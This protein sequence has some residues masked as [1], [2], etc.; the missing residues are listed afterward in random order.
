[1]E[2]TTESRLK[3]LTT[4]SGLVIQFKHEKGSWPQAIYR[5][6]KKI[7]VMVTRRTIC[8]IVKPLPGMDSASGFK[9]EALCSPSDN[10]EYEL[11]RQIALFDVLKTAPREA[12]KEVMETYLGRPGAKPWRLDKNGHTKPMLTRQQTDRVAD[13]AIA[14]ALSALL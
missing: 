1:M 2:T 12:R 11:G 3:K 13:A 9:G 8:T 4:P 10:F 6:G 14:G 7:E 5:R